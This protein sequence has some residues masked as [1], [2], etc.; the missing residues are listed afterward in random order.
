ML[1]ILYGCGLRVSELV[2]LRVGQVN[3]R[4]GV[5][6]VIGKGD[7]ERLIP[8]GE[9]GVDWLLRYMN[10][11]RGDLLRGRMSDDL[12]PGNR[13]TAMTRQAFWYRIRHYAQRAGIRKKLS[14][15]TLRHAFATHLLNHLAP[16]TLPVSGNCFD[17]IAWVN[18]GPG[19]CR[20][21]CP[22]VARMT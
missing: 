5:V 10:E 3:L 20:K 14:P 1:E 13:G 21:A 15:H 8:L 18:C 19:G 9:E 7:K 6:R 17:T 16:V 22:V 12:F 4:Q 2:S 11:A